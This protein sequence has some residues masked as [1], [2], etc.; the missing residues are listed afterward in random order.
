[1]SNLRYCGIDFKEAF[2]A[3]TVRM[4]VSPG[5]SY[6]QFIENVSPI[7]SREFEIPKEQLELV[8]AGQYIHGVAPENAPALN[9]AEI[10]TLA[11]KWGDEL[12]YLSFYIRRKREAVVANEE[13]EIR[14]ATIARNATIESEATTLSE[15]TTISE[16]GI[17]ISEAMRRES[18]RTSEVADCPICYDENVLV[19]TRFQCMHNMCSGCYNMCQ[20]REH[21]CNGCCPFCRAP[22]R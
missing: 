14:E 12:K 11:R 20:N 16:E 4:L 9:P 22:R 18:T 15:A 21:L 10:E 6:T 8:E 2:G 19:S 7:L 5:W 3:D 1:M 17:C 13:I